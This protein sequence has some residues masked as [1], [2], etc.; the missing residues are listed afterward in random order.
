MRLLVTRPE[1]EASRFAK[2]LEG[3]GHQALVTPLFSIEGTAEALEGTMAEVE[4]IALTSARALAFIDRPEALTLPLFA[5][6]T[7][8]AEAARRKGFVDVTDAGGD[9]AALA[10]RLKRS[11]PVGARVFHPSGEDQARDLSALLAGSGLVVERRIVYRAVAATEMP[12]A[13]IS[14][15][16]EA[17]L[18]GVTFFSPRTAQTFVRLAA[19]TGLAATTAALAA[20]CLSPAVAAGLTDSVWREIHSASRPD[21]AG[22]LETIGCCPA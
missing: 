18:E 9:A 12:E 11:L 14:A 1:P 16:K 21:L 13:A 22:M 10:E 4:A 19:E 8:S 3:L 20:Y 2:D 17:R 5:V 7:A 6:G 15:L